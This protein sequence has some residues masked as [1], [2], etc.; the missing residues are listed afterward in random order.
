MKTYPSGTQH[1]INFETQRAVIVEVGGGIRSYDDGARAVLDPYPAEAMC[2]GAH[3]TPLVPWPNRLKDGKYRFG[4]NEFQVAITEPSKNNAIHGFLRW[5][6]WQVVER[7]ANHVTMGNRI[8]PQTGYPFMVELQITYSLGPQGLEVTLLASNIGDA[9]CPFGAGQHPYLSPGIGYIDECL[10][11]VGA[12]TMLVTDERQIPTGT[13]D[14]TGTAFDFRSG[15]KL[16]AL[17]IDTA[18]GDLIRDENGLAWITL[19]GPDGLQSSIWV[20]Q[21]YKYLEVF[22]GDTLAD[23]RKRVG[24]G[25][26]PMTCPPNAFQSGNDLITL[27]PGSQTAFKWGAKLVKP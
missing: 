5:S 21:T 6:N 22:T 12:Q 4:D 24:L 20:D 23:S 17:Q 15:K 1:E 18:F 7:R 9:P 11:T 25:A 2:D 13:T 19:L 3:G 10:L 8:Y 27:Q 16:G 26:E 14:V